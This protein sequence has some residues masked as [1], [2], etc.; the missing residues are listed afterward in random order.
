MISWFVSV[1]PYLSIVATIVL[2]FLTLRKEWGEYKNQWLRIA[3]GCVLIALGVLSGVSLYLDSEEKK[4]AR[5]NIKGLEGKVTAANDA[6]RENTKLFLDSL[7]KLSAEV[8]KL[9][10]EV[11]T[12]TL[13]KKLA[14]VEA[15]LQKTQQALAP[16]PKAA[17]TFS[18]YPFLNPPSHASMPITEMKL[19]ILADGNVRIEF[20]VVNLTDVDALDGHLNFIICKGCKF[21]KELAGFR[22]L[23]GQPETQRHRTFQRISARSE[24]T[25]TAEIAVP[26]AAEGI[27]VALNYRCR[28]CIIPKE[29]STGRVYFIR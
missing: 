8:S 14:T 29:N 10:T 7:S 24:V 21:A 18:F 1:I 9:Q 20:A 13:Q 3:V 4:E 11:K 23:E 22:Q 27:E 6:Q 5:E 2:G 19:P 15:E 12:E 17:L 16:P 25:M 28:T 26:P